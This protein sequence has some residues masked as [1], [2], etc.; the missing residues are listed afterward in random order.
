MSVEHVGWAVPSDPPTGRKRHREFVASRAG[1]NAAGA[2]GMSCQGVCQDRGI[3]ALPTPARAVDALLGGWSAAGRPRIL[4]AAV[5]GRW[6]SS[7]SVAVPV[8]EPSARALV[9]D[10]GPD[11][12]D[13]AVEFEWL[14]YPLVFVGAR[15]AGDPGGFA[16]GVVAVAA[17]D[18]AEPLVA[19]AALAGG[20]PEELDH[21]EL[22][23]AN[24][25]RSVGPL[26]LWTRGDDIVGLDVE[27]GLSDHSRLAR[28]VAP[29]ALEISFRRPRECWLGVEV[30]TPSDGQHVVR[31][32]TVE[33]LVNRTFAAV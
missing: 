1:P 11:D 13:V 15:R 9:R 14:G 12:A 32:A 26:R 10:A 16:A 23:A 8:D 20:P 30:S 4:Q 27:A 29:V 19:L 7:R 21:V 6:E 31:A 25:W 17:G 5:D 28:C 22:G 2:D 3:S 33:R 24:A 18:L